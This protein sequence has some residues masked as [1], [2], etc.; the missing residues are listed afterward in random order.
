MEDDSRRLAVALVLM[1]YGVF[2]VMLMWTLDKFVHP[3][4]AAHVFEKFYA[5]TGL[6]ERSMQCIAGVEM[7]LL[8]GFLLGAKKTL[9]YG[10]VL[11][12][13][14]L[15][16]LA[17][18]RQYLEPFDNLL[19]FA[20]IPMLGACWTLFSLREHDTLLSLRR[21]AWGCG[22]LSWAESKFRK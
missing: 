20:A 8:G 2:I 1:R 9:T 12:V 21:S 18:W 10:F 22:E 15:S 19:F 4:H 3:A 6:G 11:S 14:T 5:V 13:H 7:L 17:A 16:T